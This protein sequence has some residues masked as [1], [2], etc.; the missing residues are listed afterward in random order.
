MVSSP[1]TPTPIHTYIHTYIQVHIQADLC[2]REAAT[3]TSLTLRYPLSE[4]YLLFVY[5]TLL[6]V[7]FATAESLQPS[8]PCTFQTSLTLLLPC[9]SSSLPYHLFFYVREL[10]GRDRWQ[11]FCTGHSEVVDRPVVLVAQPWLCSVCLAEVTECHWEHCRR[12]S[13]AVL[14]GGLVDQAQS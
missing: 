7:V 11:P 12:H 2:C 13:R 1:H 4:A 8:F 10:L 5:G 14:H 3:K 6:F 9:L